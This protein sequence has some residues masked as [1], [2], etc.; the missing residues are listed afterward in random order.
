MKIG[1]V[2]LGRMGANMSMRLLRAGHE[3]VAFDPHAE[4]VKSLVGAGAVGSGSLAELVQ[5]LEAPRAVW[6]MVP[7]AVVDDTIAKLAPLLS[8]DD[9]IIDGGNSYYRDD[10]RRAKSL[11]SAGI[12]YVD[13]GT[14]GGVWGKE[15]GYCQ[16]IGGDAD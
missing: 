2:G 15:R 10:L 5:K 7:A 4:Q 3:I 13:V 12:R 16:M 14:S 11:A 8:R 1:M 9:V 6:L